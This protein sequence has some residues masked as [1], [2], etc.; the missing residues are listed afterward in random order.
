MIKSL[1]SFSGIQ[2]CAKIIVLKITSKYLERI[3]C[4]HFVFMYKF[5]TIAISDTKICQFKILCL[6]LCPNYN[7]II[8]RYGITDYIVHP[9]ID[10]EYCNLS[11]VQ[12]KL[13]R[14]RCRKDCRGKTK[15]NMWDTTLSSIML[16]T[17]TPIPDCGP[18]PMWQLGR[19]GSNNWNTMSCGVFYLRRCCRQAKFI[20]CNRR[21]TI[22]T[23]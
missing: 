1:Y 16:G 8:T 18:Y 12:D 9:F 17:V 4:A 23:C 11:S 14:R 6:S 2:V 10:S 13:Y 5:C 20:L 21:R 19:D 3:F 15:G 22:D 7:S